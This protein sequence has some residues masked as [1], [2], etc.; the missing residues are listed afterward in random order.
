MRRGFLVVAA[1]LSTVA[2]A[3]SSQK[4]VAAPPPPAAAPVVALEEPFRGALSRWNYYRQAAGLPPV[5]AD[6]ALDQAAQ[7]HSKYIVKNQL[8][9]ADVLIEHGTIREAAPSSGIRDESPGNPWYTEAGENAARMGIVLRT[10][11]PAPDGG[12]LVDGLIA[13]G[14]NVFTMLDPQLAAIGY[15]QY[16]EDS[17]CV[18]TVTG[19][20]GLAHDQFLA[21]YDASRFAWNPSLG[22]MPFTR[23]Q[24]KHPIFFPSPSI[25]AMNSAEGISW[26]DP[27]VSCGYKGEAGAPI[28]LQV[29]ASSSGDDEVRLSSY[30]LSED[31]TQVESC[32]FDATS[33]KNPDGYEQRQARWILHQYGAVMMLP[34]EPL[35]PGHTYTVSMT[36]D[37]TPYNWNFTVAPD[38]K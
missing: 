32:A 25:Q 1:A 20:L 7:A 34:R 2:A 6:P 30:S 4:P 29:G 19:R 12:L 17:D 26:P 9:G 15:G 31:G 27:Q 5:P 14:F 3:C 11:G 13:R 36:A 24:L 28:T 10:A 16:C 8:R 35:K 23:A 38:A 37:G 18:V 21:L 22:D 33:Y